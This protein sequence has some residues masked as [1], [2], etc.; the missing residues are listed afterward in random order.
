MPGSGPDS[1]TVPAA[2]ELTSSQAP[3]F[4]P[5]GRQHFWTWPFKLWLTPYTRM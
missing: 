1:V 3:N 4:G 5:V 2:S